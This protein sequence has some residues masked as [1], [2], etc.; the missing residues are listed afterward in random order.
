MKK[1]F[2]IFVTLLIILTAI[3]VSPVFADESNDSADDPIIVATNEPL[4]PFIQEITPF[5]LN[6]KY[7][8]GYSREVWVEEVIKINEEAYNQ[9]IVSVEENDNYYIFNFKSNPELENKV[10]VID[11]EE[12]VNVQ[13]D[14]IIYTKPEYSLKISSGISL[15]ALIRDTGSGGTTKI[16]EYYGWSSGYQKYQS[17][18]GKFGSILNLLIG[19]VPTK[20]VIVSWVLSEALGSV[21]KTLTSGTYVTAETYNKYYYRNKVG[22][23]YNSIINQ[24]LPVAHVGERRSFGWSWGTYINAYGEPIIKK[25]TVKNANNSKNPTNYDSREKKAHYDDN[26]WIINKA[27]ETQ[28]TGGY[29]DCFGIATNSV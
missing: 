25:G 3:S 24:W 7:S 14:R 2:S 29:W 26:T 1:L 21:Y 28:Y 5:S 8:V 11:G 6:N 27:I 19:Y 20:S 12:Y 9:I 23:V 18:S 4:M 10:V 15:N 16:V 13:V 17:K 22:C